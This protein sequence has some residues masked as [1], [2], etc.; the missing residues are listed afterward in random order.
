MSLHEKSDRLVGA[1]P[2]FYLPSLDPSLYDLIF[3]DHWHHLHGQMGAD[4]E[5]RERKKSRGKI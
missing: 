5:C 3:R 2:L 1:Q 4:D